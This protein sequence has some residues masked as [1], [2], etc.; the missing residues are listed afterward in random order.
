M[1]SLM[2]KARVILA[3][4]MHAL[5]DRQVNTPEGY[6]QLI[7]DIN[8]AVYD[9]IAANDEAQGGIVSLERAI[10]E[11]VNL[12]AQKRA[13]ATLL[14]GDD[15]HENDAH[16]SALVG[17]AQQFDAEVAELRAQQAMLESQRDEVA[18]AISK[19]KTRLSEMQAQLQRLRIVEAGT[20][21]KNRASD[22][23]ERAVGA[24]NAAEGVDFGSVETEIRH[25]GDVADVRFDRVIGELQGVD[26]PEAAVADVKVRQEIEFMK[27]QIAAEARGE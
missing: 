15:N 17:Q 22:A 19:L 14:L 24:V 13:D 2:E 27:T 5:L 11:K 1:Q 9:L 7:R 10:I 3:A 12:S 21:A 25:K 8:A 23:A 6:A 16:A 26:S 4:K 18:A 20:K